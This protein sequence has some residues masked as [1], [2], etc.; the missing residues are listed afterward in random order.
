M[1]L[2]RLALGLT[3]LTAIWLVGLGIH[4]LARVPTQP[5]ILATETPANAASTQSFPDQAARQSRSPTQPSVILGSQISDVDRLLQGWTK[6]HHGAGPGYFKYDSDVRLVVH[7]R[8]GIA[9]GVAILSL[10]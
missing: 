4:R 3:A 8:S 9:V 2:Q 5:D 6:S 1:R 7:F 10:R